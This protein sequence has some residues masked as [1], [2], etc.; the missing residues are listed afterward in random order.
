MKTVRELR[1]KAASRI[2]KGSQVL[3]TSEA[4]A[5]FAEALETAQVGGAVIGF[6][7]YGRTVAALVPVEAVYVLAGLGH[8]L[9]SAT[10]AAIKR[11]AKSFVD[12]VPT[13]MSG[14]AATPPKGALGK[15]MAKTAKK[16]GKTARGRDKG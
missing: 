10:V 3:S 5:N 14:R 4:R 16:R 11:Q 1:K 6:D 12:K 8:T 13:R 7:R 2:G 9:P 15:K